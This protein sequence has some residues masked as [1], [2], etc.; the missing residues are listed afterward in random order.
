MITTVIGSYPLK[1]EDLGDDAIRMSVDEQVRAGIDLVS[2]GQTR[3]DMIEYFARYIDGYTMEDKSVVTG[4]IGHGHADVFVED[5][6]LAKSIHPRVKSPVTGPVTL[7]FSSRIKSGYAGYRDESLYLDTAA[8][9]LDI[10]RALEA[11]GAE[12]LQID[13]PFLSVGAPMHI[14]RK[15]IEHIAKGVKIPVA[16]HVCGQ[17]GKI[18]PQLLEWDGLTLLSH[19]FMGEKNDDVLQ[20][21]LLKN[22]PK[23]LGLGCIDTKSPKVESREDVVALIQKAKQHIPMDRMIIHPDCGLRLMPH[24]AAFQKLSVMVAAAREAEQT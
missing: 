14:A 17:V 4:P 12:W 21:D 19:G 13:E 9:L 11:E 15:A 24:D 23:M 16:L 8:A 5:L 6:K 18:L 1:Y 20:S 2:D 10:A 7:V 3:F 22:S